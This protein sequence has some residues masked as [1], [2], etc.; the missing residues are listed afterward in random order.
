MTNHAWKSSL[1]DSTHCMAQEFMHILLLKRI[2]RVIIQIHECNIILTAVL[3]EAYT[4]GPMSIC[5]CTCIKECI[6]A[7][8]IATSAAQ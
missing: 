6:L 3:A 5:T 8:W 4:E 1:L 2:L 7:A